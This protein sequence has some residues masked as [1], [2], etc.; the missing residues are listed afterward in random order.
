MVI[1][2]LYSGSAGASVLVNGKPVYRGRLTENAERI[3]DHLLSRESL[4]YACVCNHCQ[5]VK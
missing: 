2:V 4:P 1:Q 3:A 5:K